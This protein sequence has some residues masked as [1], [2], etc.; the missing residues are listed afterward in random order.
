ML[1]GDAHPALRQALESSG[2]DLEHLDPW[3]AWR[4]FKRFLHR[5]V[6]GCYDAASVQF[7]LFPD[8]TLGGE[9]A[10][11][12]LVRQFTERLPPDDEDQL[13]GRVVIE[14]RYEPDPFRALSW[15]EAWTLDFRTLEEWASVAEGLACFQEAMTRRPTAT[16]VYYEAGA[17]DGPGR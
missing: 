10:T 3:E 1:V 8:S 11:L 6:E 16:A 5:E 7:D 14:L 4:T 13:I 9:E 17:D 2:Q 12:L 15:A